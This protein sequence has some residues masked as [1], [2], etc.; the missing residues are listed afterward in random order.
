MSARILLSGTSGLL[1]TALRQT[2]TRREI[3]FLQ[4]VR[5]PGGE[6]TLLWNP[7]R[8]PAFAHPEALEGCRAAIHLSGANIAG[9]RW[10][11]SYRRTLLTSRVES[12]RA[13]AEA[14]THLRYPPEALLVSSAV[15]LYGNGGDAELDE[16]NQV[17]DGFLAELCEKWE[18]AAEP[19]RKAGIRVVHLR[20]GVILSPRGGALAKLLPL[21]RMGLG[22]PIASGHQWM[23]WISLHDAVEAILF[24]LER[25]SLRG[26]V[27]LTAPEPVTNAA[28][29]RALGK[30]LHRPALLRVPAFALRLAMGEM[31]NQTL[32]ASQRVYPNKLTH[33][34]F[35]FDHPRIDQ[36]LAA[37]LGRTDR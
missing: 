13:L 29:T 22:G 12:T 5:S 20:T 33:A 31:A 18:A 17:G 10:T 15:G 26:P 28:F 37:L 32:L 36:A 2:M 30:A 11:A 9:H 35:H 34:G 7:G 21:F 19:A 23:S 16:G 4:L 8:T 1:G 3:R 24:L 25:R 14:L 6:G 27:N